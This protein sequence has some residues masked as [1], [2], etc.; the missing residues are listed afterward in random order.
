MIFNSMVIASDHRG[1]WLKADI[2]EY[3]KNLGYE[4]KDCGTDSDCVS[5]DYPNYSQK[6]T[7][8]LLLDENSFGVLICHSGIGMNIAANR[9]RGI[10][11][12][13]CYEEEIAKLAREHNNANVICFGSGFIDR[14]Y[15]IKC[16]ETFAHTK[17][18]ERHLP[19]I[20]KIDG[21]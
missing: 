13:L 4:V 5:V 21:I 18:D 14:E 8:Y 7:D 11:G 15:A 1:Y 3:F 20:K 17:F 16:V 9:V 12:V 10:R 19:R 2:L 6:V